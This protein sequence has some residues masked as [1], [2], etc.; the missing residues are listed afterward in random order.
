MVEGE[1]G[2]VS[3]ILEEHN[4]KSLGYKVVLAVF[5]SGCSNLS[6]GTAPEEPK[7]QYLK[8]GMTKQEVARIIGTPISSYGT[9]GC[10]THIYNELTDAF[11]IYANYKKGLLQSATDQH[12]HICYIE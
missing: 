12:K 8:V 2:S 11:F 5:L 7:L 3:G 1:S 9:N 6:F 10:D 4:M